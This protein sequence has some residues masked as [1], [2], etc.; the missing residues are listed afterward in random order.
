MTV[1]DIGWLDSHK[2]WNQ[3]MH[4]LLHCEGT[5]EGLRLARELGHRKV[6]PESDSP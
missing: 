2:P 4:T 1:G 5:W 3:P 6:L